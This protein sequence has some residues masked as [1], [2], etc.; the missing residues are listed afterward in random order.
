MVQLAVHYTRIF[1]L[2]QVNESDP[3]KHS[4]SPITITDCPSTGYNIAI[5]VGA[6]PEN[7]LAGLKCHRAW[8]QRALSGGVA[9]ANE[10]QD[11][12]KGI[13]DKFVLAP[14]EYRNKLEVASYWYMT[15]CLDDVVELPEDPSQLMFGV[16]TKSWTDLDNPDFM[17][18]H[19]ETLDYLTSWASLRI[20]PHRFR[21]KAWNGPLV[22]LP[23]SISLR[24]PIFR[25]GSVRL[26]TAPALPKLDLSFFSSLPSSATLQS[27]PM[28]IHFYLRSIYE[29]DRI[30]RFFESFRGLEGLYSNDVFRKRFRK[31]ATLSVESGVATSQLEA[32]KVF[33]RRGS[34]AK[35]LFATMALALFPSDA[36]A[37]Y[38]TFVKLYEW[39][40]DLAHGRRKLTVDEVP[41]EGAFSLLHKYLFKVCAS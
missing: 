1:A 13:E 38:N 39:R 10:L 8:V 16:C 23:T 14:T 6:V 35:V 25:G 18:R 12:A 34:S 11:H 27:L 26:F 20:E 30:A 36:D 4:D 41:D 3:V 21:W 29:P 17:E 24:P 19:T 33:K 5:H 22:D 32:L 31:G 2:G 7:I 40:N 9:S 28:T 15:F 37:D